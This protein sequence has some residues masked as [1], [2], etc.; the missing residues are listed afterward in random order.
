MMFA[1]VAIAQLTARPPPDS[2]SRHD[3]DAYLDVGDDVLVREKAWAGMADP[4]AIDSGEFP[5]VDEPLQQILF[6]QTQEAP[7]AGT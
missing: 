2:T 4:A 1:P 3:I 7:K 6:T 5:G